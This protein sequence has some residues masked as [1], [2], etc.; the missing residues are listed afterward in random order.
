MMIYLSNFL[1]NKNND[2][3]LF[4]FSHDENLFP[5]VENKFLITTFNNPKLVSIL[6]IAYEIRKYD[7]IFI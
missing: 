3:K 2:V 4:T 5:T 6:K 1:S 7:Y